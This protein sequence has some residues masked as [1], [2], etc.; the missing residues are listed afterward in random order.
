HQ[1]RSQAITIGFHQRVKIVATESAQVVGVINLKNTVLLDDSKQYQ[2]TQHGEHVDA[3]IKDQQ[4]N[5][6]EGHCQGQRRQNDAWIEPGL[7]LRRQ[8][9][10][11]EGEGHGECQEEACCR[12]F[13]R[14]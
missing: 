3:L 2:E 13:L 4:T 11:H 1:D 7:K 12:D 5:E 6:V 10:V 14:F 8:D 9:Q